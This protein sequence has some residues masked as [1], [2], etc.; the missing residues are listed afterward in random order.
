MTMV[1]VNYT[2]DHS[3]AIGLTNYDNGVTEEILEVM[4]HGEKK[5]I[6]QMESLEVYKEDIL[7]I[8][9]RSAWQATLNKR[10]FEDMIKHFVSSVQNKTPFDFP[11]EVG[12][13]SHE[14]A[15][16]IVSQLESQL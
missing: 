14:V 3:H 5:R 7:Q 11:F 4:R 16:T 15:E 13:K 2:S 1:V 6:L 12:L 9:T 10:G 8:K